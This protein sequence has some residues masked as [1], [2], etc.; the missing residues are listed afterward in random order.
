MEPTR[1]PSSYSHQNTINE[2]VFI[3]FK[4]KENNKPVF[5]MRSVKSH[6]A[7]QE[8]KSIGE[9]V[10]KDG[11][12]PAI[13]KRD[14]VSKVIKEA[15]ISK[16]ASDLFSPEDFKNA[17]FYYKSSGV[18][19]K[20]STDSIVISNL[21]KEQESLIITAFNKY[22]EEY[23]TAK[24]QV[25]EGKHKKDDRETGKE[26][27]KI[28]ARKPSTVIEHITGRLKK[29]EASKA[30]AEKESNENE[31]MHQHRLNQEVAS[32]EKGAKKHE[33]ARLEREHDD[34][35]KRV[36]QDFRLT[37]EERTNA[38]KNAKNTSEGLPPEP[39][40]AKTK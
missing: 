23:R 25:A 32:K 31:I 40:K 35:R 24:L 6:A 15:I 34:L 14:P 10:K 2:E 30:K 17:E 21:S 28:E 9:I 27:G 4:T 8:S 22:L 5:L 38:I 13:L 26:E 39:K 7:S 11:H 16:E 19:E 3:K 18:K 1:S 36:E 37:D 29:Q 12:F 20:Q 33:Q